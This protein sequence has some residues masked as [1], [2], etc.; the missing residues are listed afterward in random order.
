MKS[1]AST[2]VG[3]LL[4]LGLAATPAAYAGTTYIPLPGISAVG[5]VSYDTQISITNNAGR[6]VAVK[7]LQLEAG[8]DGTVRE[9][10]SASRFAVVPRKTVMY[11]P[12]PAARG[13]LQL[14][15]PEGLV[16]RAQLVGTD[17]FRAELP[18]IDS[19]SLAQADDTL[20]IEGLEGSS[21][22][23]SDAVLVN[24]GDTAAVCS[25]SVLRVDGTY[26]IDPVE[27]S[28]SPLSHL[29]F[30]DIFRGLADDISDANLEVTCSN[31]FYAYA[32]T[33]DAATGRLTIAEPSALANV[34]ALEKMAKSAVVCS[35]NSMLC[36]L[37]NQVHTSTKA[38][39]TRAVT[40]TPPPGTYSSILG[41]V[42]V[43]V[44]GWNRVNPRG[45]HGA[46][47]LVINKN[48]LLLGSLFLRG[49]GKN[50]VTMRHGVCAGACNKAK[51]EKG[52]PV[53]LGQTYIFDYVYD[54]A[55]KSILMRVTN[56]GNLIAVIQD[57]PNINRIEIK[58]GDKVLIGLSNPG[59]NSREEPASL[60]WTY[61][62][63]RV[64][65]FR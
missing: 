48:K 23:I 12:D 58:P 61:S 30:A 33:T 57:K 13:L 31:D 27:I 59:V 21:S 32:Q 36:N 41:H 45:A 38:D 51:I 14:D 18:V 9:G 44:A 50:S 60:G 39:P 15:A 34:I 37:P 5:P 35:S 10:L 47:Y 6:R 53:Q 54:P 19:G 40:M 63:V 2:M 28:L 29:V 24:L 52:I 3:V 62:N 17:G 1:F 22:K 4:P 64:E 25:A 55:R 16:Y 11:R 26:A 20:V 46:L 8:E 7:S 43:K 49:P 42:E 56:N 65:L